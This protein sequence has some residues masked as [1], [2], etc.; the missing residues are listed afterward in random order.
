ML[1][2]QAAEMRRDYMSFVRTDLGLET[3][4]SQQLPFATATFEQTDFKA[5]LKLESHY[6]CESSRRV[7]LFSRRQIAASKA[8]LHI[9]SAQLDYLARIGQGN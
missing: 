8:R 1:P 7:G 4:V 9:V 6:L 3:E 5:L 2:A